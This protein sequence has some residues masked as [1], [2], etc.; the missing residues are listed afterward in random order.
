MEMYMKLL[1]LTRKYKRKWK[2]TM[3]PRNR[4]LKA[5]LHGYHYAIGEFLIDLDKLTKK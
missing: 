3:P 4:K 2:N 1:T 5:F